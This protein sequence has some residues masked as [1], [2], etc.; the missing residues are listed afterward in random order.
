MDRFRLLG[1]LDRDTFAAEGIERQL[2]Q[3]SGWCQSG[4]DTA[5]KIAIQV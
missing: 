4:A 5:N 3:A 1:G 2:F